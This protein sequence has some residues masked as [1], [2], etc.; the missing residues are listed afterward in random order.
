M[1]ER[2]SI[3]EFNDY[4]KTLTADLHLEN[5][6][7]MELEE[8]WIQHLYDH[9]ESLRRQYVIEEEAVRTAI[10]QF[11]EIQ[12]LQD[13]VNQT[14]PSAVKQHAQ[15]EITIGIVCLVAT[16]IG[17][18]ILI[19]ARPYVPFLPLMFAY[20]IYR[21]VIS[22]QKNAILSIVGFAA[23]YG[24]FF[25]FLPKIINS[26]LTF[27]LYI[28]QLFSL[29][30][31][32]LTGPDGLFQFVTLHMMWYVILIKQLLDRKN[33]SPLWKRMSNVSFQYWAMLLVGLFLARFQSSGEMGVLFLNVFLLYAFLQQI[34]SVQEFKLW[35]EKL[36]RLI[37][38]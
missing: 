13:E 2:D 7:K 34:V 16:L 15:K 1:S 17:P 25:Q 28:D 3:K 24:C 12:M 20:F 32:Q 35:K 38:S 30:W 18:A 9:Y 23:I 31:N 27:D 21:F 6:E 33:Y 14:Y 10:D 19:G 36:V 11:G 8:E 37:V 4:I 29:E 5:E 22:Q 26:P